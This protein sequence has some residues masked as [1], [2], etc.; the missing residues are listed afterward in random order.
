MIEKEEKLEKKMKPG[1][2]VTS[3]E[4]V[5]KKAKVDDNTDK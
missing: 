5:P 3:S 2:T 4:R 1:A